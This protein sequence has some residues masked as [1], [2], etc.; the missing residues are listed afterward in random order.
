MNDPLSPDYCPITDILEKDMSSMS[1]V[2]LDQFIAQ[3]KKLV[4]SPQSL[5]AAL[6]SGV[7][8]AK[9]VKKPKDKVNLSFLGL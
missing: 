6:G 5:K 8:S 7:A 9:R 2:E 1:D 3:S 4:E